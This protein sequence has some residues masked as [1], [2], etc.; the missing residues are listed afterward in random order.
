MRS[1]CLKQDDLFVYVCLLKSDKNPIDTYQ[2]VL[3]QAK[4]NI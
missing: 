1:V 2:Y 4:F 3:G